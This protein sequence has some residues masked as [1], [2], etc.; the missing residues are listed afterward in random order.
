MI[1]S[2]LEYME[3]DFGGVDSEVFFPGGCFTGVAARGNTGRAMERVGMPRK[4]DFPIDLS[5]SFEDCS[6]TAV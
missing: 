4:R 5:L 2:F 3:M 6:V 1:M